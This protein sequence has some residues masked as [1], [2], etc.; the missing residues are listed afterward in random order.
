M[1][2]FLTTEGGRLLVLGN[3]TTG[4]FPTTPFIHVTC[5]N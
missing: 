3:Q 4:D 5:G 2:N 1:R